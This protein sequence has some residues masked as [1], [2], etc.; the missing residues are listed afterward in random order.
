MS[1][2]FDREAWEAALSEERAAKDEYIG[3]HPHSPLP[4]AE[5]PGFDGLD[6]YPPDPD[7]RFVV[8]LDEYDDHD[9]VTVETTHEGERT[10]HRWGELRFT[11]DGA[12]R[13]LTAFRADPD[14]DRFWV[15]F[16][17]GTSGDTT[18]GAGR[19]LDLDPDE[20]R[21]DGEWVLDFNEAYN[22]YC[23]YSDRYECPLPPVE[24]WLDVAIEAGERAYHE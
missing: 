5:R 15:P 18:Y 21:A 6:Y 13:S 17:D 23:A 12:E 19:Y 20:H 1:Q 8:P 16:R 9:T 24:N 10:Y 3:E 14:E 22:P 11:L 4:D 2:Q 7:Y